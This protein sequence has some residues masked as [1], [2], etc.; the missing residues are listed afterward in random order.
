MNA[1]ADD[2][3]RL[4]ALF[5]VLVPLVWLM[6][7][8][9]PR[10]SP[11]AGRGRLSGPRG[12]GPQAGPRR[13][14][15]AQIAVAGRRARE[16]GVPGAARLRGTSRAE[17]SLSTTTRRTRARRHRL[18][19]EPRLQERVGADLAAEV[20]LLG[21]RRPPG[22]AGPATSRPGAPGV[23]PHSIHEPS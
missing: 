7:R 18:E 1:F 12:R 15:I 13:V 8:R 21:A 3:L 23:L 2:F 20:Q 6:R 4:A 16:H 9:R 11:P 10:P 14:R 22:V 5:A 19:R 17:V